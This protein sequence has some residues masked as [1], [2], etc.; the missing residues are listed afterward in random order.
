MHAAQHNKTGD[1]RKAPAVNLL[2]GKVRKEI[3]QILN[4]VAVIVK[5]YQLH[6]DFLTDFLP[7]L[8]GTRKTLHVNYIVRRHRRQIIS[9]LAQPEVKMN[10]SGDIRRNHGRQTV[11]RK[12]PLAGIFL[13]P[14]VP[15][16]LRVLQK[17]PAVLPVNG[18]VSLAARKRINRLVF[19][20]FVD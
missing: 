18:N 3:V 6:P 10:A 16:S 11:R 13:L 2:R 7:Y 20:F 8:V 5:I 14:A 1:L 15:V 17:Q 4:P 9:L 19:F 12:K